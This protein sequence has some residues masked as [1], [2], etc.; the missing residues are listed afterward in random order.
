MV[1]NIQKSK[2]FSKRELFNLIWPLLVEQLLTVL[3]GMVDVLMV[4][5]IG[6][7]AVSGVSLVDAVNNLIIQVLFALTAGGTVVCA[8]YIGAENQE[9][10]GKTTAQLLVLTSFLTACVMLF[11]IVGGNG[12]LRLLFGK[13]EPAVLAD[14][15]IYLRITAIS[16]PFLAIYHSAAAVFRAEGNTRIAMLFSLFMNGVNIVGNAICIFVLKM[17]VEGVA[18]PTLIARISGAA[19]ML[20]MLE[21]SSS[22]AKIQN[23]KACI[24][25]CML[26]KRIL[27][28]GVPNG[29]ESSVF[30]FGKLMLQSLVSTLGT[31]SIAGFAVAS[32]LVT[33]LYLPG[34][35]LG[36]ATLTVVGQCYGAGEKKQAKQYMKLLLLLNYALLVVICIIMFAG[37]WK[38]IGAYHLTGE[39]AL[40]AGRLL[41]AH[42]IA[43]VLWPIA[44]L[45]PYYFRAIGKATFTM[46]VA[47][48]TMWSCRIGL[49]YIFIKI[50]HMS[51]L[52]VWYAMFMDWLVR[53]IVYVIAFFPERKG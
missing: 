12:L 16:F 14:A 21:K 35:A 15:G 46:I 53:F 36:A 26:M 33:Y 23:I 42:T 34:N 7:A 49:A 37:R 9:K 11:F 29:V 5:V 2:I 1:K 31:A 50:L 19:G 30:Q 45:L 39:S 4:A 28:I 27:R 6:E 13:V 40:L 41:T 24:P 3:V 22:R 25:D 18:I 51:V 52:G 10:A 8:Q 48:L 44:F 47:L 43:M 32:N 17:G 38:F 20:I